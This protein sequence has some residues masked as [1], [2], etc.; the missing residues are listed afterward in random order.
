MN[1][2]ITD[3]ARE[4]LGKA[5]SEMKIQNPALRILFKGFG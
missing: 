3:V 4:N 5:F 2:T 1:I